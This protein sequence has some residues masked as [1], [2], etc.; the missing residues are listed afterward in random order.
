VLGSGLAADA[1]QAI[2]AQQRQKGAVWSVRV[3]A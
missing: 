2:I 3:D 1:A